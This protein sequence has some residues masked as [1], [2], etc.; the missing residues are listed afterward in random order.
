MNFPRRVYDEHGRL[1]DLILDEDPALEAAATP[2][3]DDPELRRPYYG[4]RHGMPAGMDGTPL[5]RGA[6]F[7]SPEEAAEYSV[8]QRDPETGEPL[9][10]QFSQ[11]MYDAHGMVQIAT[12]D[13][14]AFSMGTTVGGD[15]RDGLMDPRAMRMDKMRD[16]GMWTTE[17]ARTPTGEEVERFVPSPDSRARDAA[18]N[19]QRQLRDHARRMETQMRRGD[20]SVTQEDVDA[21][22]AGTPTTQLE[23]YN[24]QMMARARADGRV[25]ARMA[26]EGKFAHGRHNINA[27]NADAIRDLIDM[28]RRN[29][30]AYDELAADN[31]GPR[32]FTYRFNPRTGQIEASSTRAYEPPEPPQDGRALMAMMQQQAAQ[33]MM[34]RERDSLASEARADA[35]YNATPND[36]GRGVDRAENKRRLIA[37]RRYPIEL[38]DSILD[39][40]YGPAGAPP[41]VPAAAPDA[42]PSPGDPSRTTVPM[43]GPD[44]AGTGM[45][46]QHR[47]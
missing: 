15:M 45:P 42:G 46:Y 17:M 25:R 28:R 47:F 3:T 1:V 19:E 24:A 41:S 37:A 2:L 35:Q 27:G 38:I 20:P 9:P 11:D 22:V 7:A 8:M 44:G 32:N 5:A 14:P 33:D 16:S 18:R 21:A 12:P 43:P 6:E 36:W 23:R 10:S 34:R 30:E 29:P 39:E 4:R 40:L 31:M 13:G 26:E